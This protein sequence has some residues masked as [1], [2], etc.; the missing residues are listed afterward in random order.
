MRNRPM[1]FGFWIFLLGVT[2]AQAAPSLSGQGLLPTE[3]ARP[4]IEQDPSVIAACA[5]L[6]AAKQEAGILEASPYEWTAK[7]SGQRRAVDTSGSNSREWNAGVERTLRLPNKASADR[8]IGEATVMEAEA[9]YGEARRQAA[10][11]LLALWLDW[12]AAVQAQELA[13]TNRQSAQENLDAVEKRSRAGDASK[14]DRNLAQAALSEQRRVENDTKTQANVAWGRLNGRFPGL[15]HPATAF[16]L[17]VPIDEDI[18]SWR[19]RILTQ[20]NALKLSHAQLQK[21]QAQS[22]RARAEKIPDPTV[23]VF[24]ASEVYGHERIT[25]VS[26]SIPIPGGQRGRRS[27]QSEFLAKAASQDMELMK[28]QLDMDIA[29]AIATAQGAYAGW[30]IAESGMSAMQE[31]ARLM[32]RA[33]TLGEADLQALLL[34]RLQATAAAQNALAARAAALKA[35]YQLL[36]DANLVWDLDK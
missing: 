1:M 10:R 25:G 5:A 21:A 4:L 17:P 16:P 15:G 20:S 11:E 31:S 33:Y 6:E 19:D 3:T 7:L 18:A 2:G 35:N 27:E 24:T 32:Q 26:I 8:R 9:R 13:S 30:E 36:I 28:R 12:L 22:G 34:V 14:L 23:G 29:S